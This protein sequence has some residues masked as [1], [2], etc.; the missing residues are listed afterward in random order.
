MLFICTVLRVP[1]PV[2]SLQVRHFNLKQYF[3]YVSRIKL[4]P[5][6][7]VSNYSI[8]TRKHPLSWSPCESAH[9]PV[10]ITSIP[11]MTSSMMSA[12]PYCSPPHMWNNHYK[13]CCEAADAGSPSQS[14]H[15]KELSVLLS[16][17]VSPC[18]QPDFNFTTWV[19]IFYVN[20]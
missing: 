2:L 8:R 14:L 5:K 17:G 10:L 16:L 18:N 19:I 13:L 6:P 7:P 9:A 3:I 4:N 20:L 1:C 11:L 15:C 12:F